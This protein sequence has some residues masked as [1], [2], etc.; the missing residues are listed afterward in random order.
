MYDFVFKELAQLNLPRRRIRSEVYG[1]AVHI[2]QAPGYPREILGKTF[3]LKVHIGSITA[4]LAA[5]AGESLLVAMER[6]GLAP[7]SSCRSG[8]CG[9]C[10]SRLISGEVYINPDRDGRRA[11]DLK[12]G[13]IHPCSS[14]PLTDLEISVPRGDQ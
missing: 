12:Y 2:E 13:W 5:A 11:A 7:P 9:Y 3:N 14:Y 1:S 10:H 8:E 4:D 6:A